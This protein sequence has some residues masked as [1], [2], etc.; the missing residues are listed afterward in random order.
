VPTVSDLKDQARAYEQQG[1]IHKALAIY[2][3]I[4]K[5][6]EGKSAVVKVLPLYVKVGDLF[7][8]QNQRVGA[9]ESYEK[10]A[11]HYATLGSA[12]RVSAL[13][14]KIVRADS[15]RN[16]VHVYFT[17]RLIESGHVASARDVL[18]DYAETVGLGQAL[19]ALD[20]L[21]G[22]PNDEVKPM[23]ERLLDS[24]G[25]G[26]RTSAERVAARVSTQL[27]RVT[28]DVAGDL[29]GVSTVELTSGGV[30]QIEERPDLTPPLIDLGFSTSPIVSA[31]PP[32]VDERST[33]AAERV[34]APAQSTDPVRVTQAPVRREE[35]QREAPVS[36]LRVPEALAPSSVAT[37]TRGPLAAPKRPIRAPTPTVTRPTR[38]PVSYGLFGF[39][40]GAASGAGL[41]WAIAV[42]R[43]DADAELRPAD[44]IV[45]MA[46][47]TSGETSDL[48]SA[49]A[50]TSGRQSTQI[51]TA[52]EI[53]LDTT[54]V[55]TSL[56][57][58]LAAPTPTGT[59]S[60]PDSSHSDT[61]LQDATNP[62][63]VAGLAIESVTEIEYRGQ[64]GY[65]VVHLLDS[66]VALTVESFPTGTDA[67]P[68]ENIG[69]IVVNVTPP[70][71]VVGVAR[72]RR[73]IVYA[74]AVIPE[75]SLLAFMSR[76]AERD[77]SN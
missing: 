38:S 57:N 74:S 19:E 37:E 7:L 50:E 11:E 53:A 67:T 31:K 25:Q 1:Q 12:R 14:T 27:Q 26:E 17:R 21:A 33:P 69:R 72:L 9:V 32:S 39:I 70:D 73:H 23:L 54:R 65:R 10:A 59:M 30:E 41:M 51:D 43:S 2:Q 13:C 6:L 3:H 46:V 71:T 77:P 64:V 49:S 60:G 20:D 76:L 22:R 29:I 18:A 40:V 75:D 44:S 16:D 4:L 68:S 52:G 63:V 5:H 61:G 28:D 8:K 56:A 36:N 42:P 24:V 47:P 45:T 35:A 34:P 15:Q 66:G 62:I 48:R 58:Q 55:G